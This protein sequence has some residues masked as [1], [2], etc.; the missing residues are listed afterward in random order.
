MLGI[1]FALRAHAFLVT[2]TTA[3]STS[4]FYRHRNALI[5]SVRLFER[6][7]QQEEEQQPPR[8]WEGFNPL[9]KTGAGSVGS[10]GGLNVQQLLSMRKIHMQELTQE[11]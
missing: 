6:R 3:T 1:L 2:T 11:S 8:E 4:S 5:P 7:Q 9:A 10:A